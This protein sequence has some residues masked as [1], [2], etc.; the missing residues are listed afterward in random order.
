MKGIA[1]KAD[2]RLTAS[3]VGS[4]EIA[5]VQYTMIHRVLTDMAEPMRCSDG[6]VAARGNATIMWRELLAR[7]PGRSGRLGLYFLM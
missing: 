2:R 6:K 1:N 4:V 3:N 7:Q 5:L